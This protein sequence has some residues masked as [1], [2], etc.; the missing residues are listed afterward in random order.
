MERPSVY[1]VGVAT[2]LKMRTATVAVRRYLKIREDSF[3]YILLDM[4]S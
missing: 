1:L 4:T 2:V 3:V